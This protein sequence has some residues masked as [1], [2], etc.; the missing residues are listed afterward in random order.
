MRNRLV[1]AVTALVAAASL[2]A[3]GSADA[4]GG[5]TLAT[6]NPDAKLKVVHSITTD[7]P[8]GYAFKKDNTELIDKINAGLKQVIDDGTWV[9]LH[10]KFE[11][12]APTPP[13]FAGKS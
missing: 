3:C 6:E 9:K 1:A 13:E 8:H 4:G 5:D 10:K 11:P 2:A 7:I 12:N